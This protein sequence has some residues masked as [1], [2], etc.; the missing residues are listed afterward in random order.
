MAKKLKAA[1]KTTA[2]DPKET[3]AKTAKVKTTSKKQVDLPAVKE[4]KGKAKVQKETAPV[5][6]NSLVEQVIS[7]REVI[8]KYPEG[9]TDTLAKKKFRQKVRNTI[10][11]LQL[12]MLKLEEG[13]KEWKAKKKELD[14]YTAETKKTA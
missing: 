10:N 13:S 7:N 11:K 3:K 4:T 12:A 5:V 14:S 6:A 9:C 1:L 2:Q 8:Y